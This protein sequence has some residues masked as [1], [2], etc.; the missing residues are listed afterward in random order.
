MNGI[1]SNSKNWIHLVLL[2]G[3]ISVNSNLFILN[4][5]G[6]PIIRNNNNCMKGFLIQLSSNIIG[7][8]RSNIKFIYKAYHFETRRAEWHN[9]NLM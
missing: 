3:F 4:N 2:L 9:Y 6:N 5:E 1:E 8:T 7:I